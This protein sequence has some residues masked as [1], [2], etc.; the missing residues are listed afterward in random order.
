MKQEHFDEFCELLDT[1]AEQYS[2]VMTQSLK[3]LYWQGLHDVEFEVVKSAL[4][5]HIRNTDKDGDFMPKISNIKKMI[6]GTT[7]DSAMVAWAKVDKAVRRVGTYRSV[8]FDDPLI[9]RVLHDMGGWISLG[10]RKE[11]EWPFVAK[12]FETRYRGFKSRSERPEY[13][14]SLIGM[15]E[16]DNLKEGF[17]SKSAVM[18]GDENLCLVVA[19]KGMNQVEFKTKKLDMNT[20]SDEANKAIGQIKALPDEGAA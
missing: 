10:Q 20:L 9:H 1:V 5:R 4:F 15:S 18:I 2:K 14:S 3:M 6:E 8:I 17:K 12:E 16:A 11:D 13:P 7:Q 19:Q